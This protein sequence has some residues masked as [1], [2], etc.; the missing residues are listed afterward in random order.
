M[1]KPLA[2][3]V[4]NSSKQSLYVQHLLINWKLKIA[5][6]F[7]FHLLPCSKSNL[8]LFLPGLKIM[9]MPRIHCIEDAII[10]RVYDPLCCVS[11]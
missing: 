3:W 6:V 8:E 1:I 9:F 5:N 10:L 7:I 4:K 11:T 2:Q